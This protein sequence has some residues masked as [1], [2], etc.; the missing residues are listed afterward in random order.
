VRSGCARWERGREQIGRL[1]NFS[2]PI[3]V[4]KKFNNW[5]FW[6]VPLSTKQKRHG[7]QFNLQ[8]GAF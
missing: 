3:L 7:F 5:I 2:R 6:V 8:K 1:Q 4:I